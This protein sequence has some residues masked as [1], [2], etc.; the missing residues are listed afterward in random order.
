MLNFALNEG[1]GV[2]A[3]FLSYYQARA[4][5]S[6]YCAL[7]NNGTILATAFEIA[8]LILKQFNAQFVLVEQVF[9]PSYPVLCTC[10]RVFNLLTDD[11]IDLLT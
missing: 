2:V 11:L 10:K 8:F 5:N 3:A 7:L 1:S 6:V 4:L 9:L